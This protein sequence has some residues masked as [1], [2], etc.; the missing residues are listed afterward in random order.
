MQPKVFDRLH[1]VMQAARAA[2]EVRL[3]AL[4]ARLDASRRRI[5][6]LRGRMVEGPADR[7]C[8]AAELTATAR[9]RTRLA[10]EIRTEQ[11]RAAE[12]AEQAGVLRTSL[13]RALGRESAASELLNQA[14]L[15]SRREAARRA[16]LVAAAPR[17]GC[18]DSGQS[19]HSE[20]SLSLP[21][22]P[23]DGS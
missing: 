23:P 9:W 21:A 20:V 15:R 8:D 11:A 12:L 5:Q 17:F 6:N 3:V 18:G 19:G 22:S 10:A 1:R 2:E 14:R 13:G 4:L 16:D 7:P